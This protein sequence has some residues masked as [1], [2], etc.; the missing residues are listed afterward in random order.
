MQPM[1]QTI[2]VGLGICMTCDTLTRT[3]R[4]YFVHFYITSSEIHKPSHT[5]SPFTFINAIQSR[6]ISH[7]FGTL[8]APLRSNQ[9]SV[10]TFESHEGV[11]YCKLHFKSLFS[12]KAVEESEPG[13]FCTYHKYTDN[14]Y[15][16]RG[17][18]P[19]NVQSPQHPQH[20]LAHEWTFHCHLH[21]FWL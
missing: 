6:S 10:D 17:V 8:C 1:Q 15:N 20:P 21:S 7:F 4:W 12:P 9:P 5:I 2:E 13:K 16:I 19:Y 14:T 11:L 3:W 18:R